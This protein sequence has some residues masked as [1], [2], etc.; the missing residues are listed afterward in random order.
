MN[1]YFGWC[2]KTNDSLKSNIKLQTVVTEVMI[3]SK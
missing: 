2:P 3:W 1:D